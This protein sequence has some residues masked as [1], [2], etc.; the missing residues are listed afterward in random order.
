MILLSHPTGNQNVR[1]A[2]RALDEVGGLESFVTSIAAGGGNWFDRL[3]RLPGGGEFNRRRFDARLMAKAHL[4]PQRELM[5]LATQRLGWRAPSRHEAGPFSVDRIYQTIDAATADRVRKSGGRLTGVYAYE[6]GA[7]ATFAAARE[8]GLLCWYDLPIGYWRVARRIQSEEAERLPEWA[9]TMPAL[10][11]S[12]AKLA[13]KDDEL[14]LAERI[15][16]ASRFT[17][18]TL[19]EA[20]FDLPVPQ[21]IP[22][23]CPPTPRD[24]TRPPGQPDRP[25]RA[26]FVGGLSQRKGL[27]YLFDAVESLK[28]ACELTVIGRRP[29]TTC[30]PLDAALARHRYLPSLPHHEILREMEHHDVLVFPSLFEGFG[31]VVTEALSRGLPVITT[32]HTCGP[33]VLDEGRD[34]FVVPIRDSAAIAGRLETLHRDRGLLNDMSRAALG[35]AAELTWQRYRQ[36]LAAA[37]VNAPPARI[38]EASCHE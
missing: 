5:R 19:K 26:L 21:V 4:H 38:P 29:A 8:A 37:V 13:R 33:D 20:P 9:G 16:V 14:R 25:L 36:A 18:E 34:G 3:S 15:L 35:K 12:E 22:Y 17:A 7:L 30:A 31:L 2:L 10:A 11:D 28:G 23:G 24:F 6:D 27:S 32:P 1:E